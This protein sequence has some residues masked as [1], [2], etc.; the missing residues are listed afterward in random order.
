M[1]KI[2]PRRQQVVLNGSAF[3]WSDVT[4]GV[5]QGSVSGPTC[6]VIFINDIGKSYS[7]SAK[8]RQK[9]TKRGLRRYFHDALLL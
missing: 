7:N 5:P 1:E 4:S 6:L 8:S 9:Q 3:D 2:L